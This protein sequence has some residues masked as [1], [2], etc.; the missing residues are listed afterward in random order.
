MPS[1]QRRTATC[2][3][4]P[5][6]DP[7]ESEVGAYTRRRAW[8][9]PRAQAVHPPILVAGDEGDVILRG[10]AG[11]GRAP[12]P[13]RTPDPPARRAGS[14]CARPAGWRSGCTRRQ[15]L[16]EMPHL[17]LRLHGASGRPGAGGDGA[18]GGV[19]PR[20]EHRHPPRGDQHWRLRVAAGVDGHGAEDCRVRGGRQ[21][22]AGGAG[23]RVVS[24]ASSAVG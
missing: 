21:G 20:I 16:G 4:A 14:G 22:K 18:G 17:R 11:C 9:L 8:L 24:R 13:Q 1:G 6:S 19:G 12:S 3:P 23:W 2:W 5:G 10:R 15:R 7:G